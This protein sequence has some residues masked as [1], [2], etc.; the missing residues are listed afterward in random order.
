M[1][2][3]P[4]TALHGITR[5][6][7]VHGIEE[8]VPIER[9]VAVRVDVLKASVQKGLLCNAG[10]AWNTLA[11]QCAGRIHGDRQRQNGDTKKWTSKHSREHTARGSTHTN[12]HSHM[13]GCIG[14][15]EFWDKWT[16][17]RMG[18]WMHAWMQGQT[19]GCTDEWTGGPT[20]GQ[21]AGK[22]DK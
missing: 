15:D 20:S 14:T 6:G 12:K 10:I 4:R 17:G 18:G 2:D 1:H 5:H 16:N 19:D 9:P 7:S 22:M 3:M 11:A 21:H 13:H 8:L